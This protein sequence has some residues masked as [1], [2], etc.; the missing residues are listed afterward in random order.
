MNKY[1][2]IAAAGFLA[3]GLS[4]CTNQEVGTL[5]GA[6]AGGV[7]GSQIGGS[8]GAVIGTIGG[9]YVGHQLTKD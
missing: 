9:G 6:V 7:I 5:G 2:A 4:G 3:I 8:T 1:I